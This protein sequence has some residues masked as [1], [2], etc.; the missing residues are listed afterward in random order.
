MV[1]HAAHRA[2][3]TTTCTLDARCDVATGY[4]GGIAVSFVAQLAHLI[5]LASPELLT[6]L[7]RHA[8]MPLVEELSVILVLFFIEHELIAGLS[9]NLSFVWVRVI[10]HL[11]LFTI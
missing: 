5:G 6:R 2:L 11:V 10:H 8:M 4:E 9:D 3:F 7:A 1:W